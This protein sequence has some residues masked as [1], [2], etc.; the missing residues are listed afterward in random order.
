MTHKQKKTLGMKLFT[1]EERKTKGLQW[2][3]TMAWKKRK[4][5]ILI[6]VLKREQPVL[7]AKLGL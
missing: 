7:T 5:A 3:D 2:F 4:L 6:R 1:A